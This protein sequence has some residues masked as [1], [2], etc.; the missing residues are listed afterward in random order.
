MQST[1]THTQHTHS[2]HT[3][4]THTQHTHTQTHT[5]TR[6]HARTHTRTHTH[7]HT[8]QIDRHTHTPSHTHTQTH[9]HS[10]R[11]T[12]LLCQHPVHLLCCLLLTVGVE[13][14]TVHEVSEGGAGCVVASQEEQ[15][16]VSQHL[17]MAQTYKC[18]SFLTTHSV[19]FFLL[20]TIMFFHIRICVEFNNPET[21]TTI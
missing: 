21:L 16:G 4:N 14:E 11:H 1:C 12:H 15:H 3:L 6:T 17:V 5:H 10:H 19:C 18:D 7:T 20:I 8:P 13:G 2:T 9:T